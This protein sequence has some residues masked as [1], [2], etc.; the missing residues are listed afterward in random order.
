MRTHRGAALVVA[1]LWSIAVCG[2]PAFGAMFNP[3][4]FTLNNGMQVVLVEN[5]R[6]PAVVQMVWYRVG[7]AD[8]PH[9]KSGI[10]HFLEHLMFKGT[11][12]IPPGQFSRIV[13]RHGGRDNAF[14]TQDYTAYYQ[15]VSADQ[16][17]LVMRMEADRMANL[18]LT[19]EVVAPERDVVLEERRARVDNS[20]AAQLAE[21]MGAT[22][23]FHHPYGTPVIG[24]ESEI[25][26]LNTE[27][28]LA[29]YRRHYAPNNAVLVVAGDIGLEELKPLAE[30]YYGAIPRRPVPPRERVSEPPHQTARRVV[31][32]SEQVR[33]PS[34]RRSYQAPTY[35]TAEAGRAYAL[36]VLSEILGGG[37]ISRLYRSL[38]VEQELAAAAGSWYD[39]NALDFSTFGVY[40][41]PRP[42][43][44]VTAVEAAVV[45]EIEKLLEHGVTEA[46]VHDAKQRLKAAAV[47]ARDDLETAAQ[48][49]GTALMTGRTIDEVEAW[50]E[51]IGAVTVA[52]VDA[53][54]KAVLQERL[55]VTGILLPA[56]RAA[57]PAAAVAPVPVPP[58]RDGDAPAQAGG[59]S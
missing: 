51:R 37:A 46:E 28:A 22:M 27:D 23:Y 21:A 25:R 2:G 36:E 11:P 32:T 59:R 34:W 33:E 44:S 40:A 48:I 20:P 30:K 41:T 26:G 24:W 45:A 13:A 10:A 15:V 7:A 4:S 19:D 49:L 18:V 1:L 57:T 53:A 55:S 52:D 54:A 38:V 31:L 58:A 39:G 9:G 56:G 42:A 16:L 14:T 50:P 3:K 12:D 6:V 35:R 8:E 29:F 5:H 17:E 47:Y 43:G